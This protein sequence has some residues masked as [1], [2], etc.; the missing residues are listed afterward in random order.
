MK[1]IHNIL[2]KIKTNK[3]L[4]V[5]TCIFTLTVIL[6][7]LAFSR[8]FCN[9]Y[10]DTVYGF[11]SDFF[12]R[13]TDGLPLPFG[14]LLMYSLAAALFCALLFGIF[15]LIFIVNS[16]NNSSFTSNA[17]HG[18]STFKGHLNLDGRLRQLFHFAKNYLKCI[19]LLSSLFLL[20]YTMQWFI[21]FRSSLL[22]E[23]RHFEKEYSTEDLR[24]LWKYAV[25][26]LNE[27]CTQV[28]R[29]KN[30]HILFASKKET[31]NEV[32]D[33]MRKLSDRY[34]RLNGFYPS[35]KPALCSDVLRWMDIGG[36]TY[37]YTMELTYNKYITDLYFPSLYAHESA[38]HQGYY[39]E[40][41]ANFLSFLSC[42]ESDDP[43]LRYSAF[44]TI[45]FYI[46]DAYL[47]AL[48][49]EYKKN[50]PGIQTLIKEY[51]N[52]KLSAQIAL[53]EKEENRK[54]EESYSSASHP[55]EKYSETAENAADIGWSTQSNVLKENGY[56]GVVQLLLEYFYG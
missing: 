40:N 25:E 31:E 2:S 49:K 8:S 47:S 41:E 50:T 45:Y 17:P 9:F 13:L 14:E 28:P 46:D 30:G 29:N 56:D 48:A 24:K 21:P 3:Y 20:T 23:S 6:N 44:H 5:L 16:K 51:Q 7:L 53:D 39:Q 42:M 43:V 27:V 18:C 34:P 33:A 55:L 36:Y 1:K 12:G 19:L 32:A 15:S 35:I 37:P 11:L 54:A 4:L 22:G 26:N 38:H 52:T 10:T